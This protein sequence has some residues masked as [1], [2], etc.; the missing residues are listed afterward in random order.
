[1]QR[2]A[3][4]IPGLSW[5]LIT[6]FCAVSDGGATGRIGLVR[7]A[8]AAMEPSAAMAQLGTDF[9]F[10][11]DFSGGTMGPHLQGERVR[12]QS[13]MIRAGAGH[14]AH[15]APFFDDRIKGGK[16]GRFDDASRGVIVGGEVRL[17]RGD[18][19]GRGVVTEQGQRPPG[20]PG[21]RL[22]AWVQ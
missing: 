1:V 22:S 9:Y 15:A 18:P 13:L 17:K 20:Y 7:A 11:P 16:A 21:P 12:L 3:H 8:V 10:R 2:Y 5:K 14:N 19:N 4:R 6:T